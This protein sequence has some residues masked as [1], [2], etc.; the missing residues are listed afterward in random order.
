MAKKSTDNTPVGQSETVVKGQRSVKMEQPKTR[1][2]AK[3][4]TRV[5][6]RVTVMQKEHPQGTKWLG[7]SPWVVIAAVIALLL[8]TFLPIYP[9]EKTV[10]KT[11]TI[12]VPVT[13]EK[14]EQVTT[15]ESIK[16]YQGYMVEQ[17]GFEAST[18]IVATTG[19]NW[20]G[21]WQGYSDVGEETMAITQNGNQVTGSYTTTKAGICQIAGTVSGYQFTGIWSEPPSYQRPDDAGDQE[22]TLA[23]DGQS[24]TGRYRNGSS[25][26]WIPLTYIRTGPGT[27]TGTATGIRTGA[28]TY[29]ID[30]VSEIVDVQRARGP[31]GTWILTLT[32]YDGTQ[33]IYRDIIKDDLTKTGKA[34]VQV[35]KT[36]NTPYTTQEPKEVV[37]QEVQKFRV[38]L[39]SL[40]MQDY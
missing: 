34:T 20:S 10:D 31:N 15:Q 21:T 22:L 39:I 26:A 40:I 28:G 11:E 6:K 5:V 38:N 12:M 23:P 33:T 4:P 29:T 7:A 13:K 9:V 35:T 14:P 25:G 27:G 3:Q 24:M 19:P 17:G 1:I 30:A 18:V 8:L 37:K 36:V 16:T 32:A 2:K